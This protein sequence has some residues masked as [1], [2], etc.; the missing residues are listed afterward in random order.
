LFADTV[1]NDLLQKC[2]EGKPPIRKWE[3]GKGTPA[4][5]VSFWKKM[6]MVGQFFF[7]SR[8]HLSEQLSNL[9]LNAVHTCEV[10]QP[11]SLWV[12]NINPLGEI[13]KLLC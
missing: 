5:N 10:N 2:R 11:L 12:K 1:T 8:T 9:V 7:F 4:L 13:I 3:Q 6:E